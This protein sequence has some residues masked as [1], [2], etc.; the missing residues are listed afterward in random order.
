M[1]Q[2]RRLHRGRAEDHTRHPRPKPSLYAIHVAD[3]AAQLH[4][5][6]RGRKDGPHRRLVHRPPGKGAVQIHHMQ[7]GRT[8]RLEGARLTGRIGLIDRGELHLAALQADAGAILQIDRRI[9][10]HAGG[11]SALRRR[12][13]V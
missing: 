2:D 1:H 13:L 8:F 3:A 10:D 12:A 4:R 5:Q 7:P 6:S 11:A 9:Q